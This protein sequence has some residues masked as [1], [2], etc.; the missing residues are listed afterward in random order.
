VQFP[1]ANDV[2]GIPLLQDVIDNF[3]HVFRTAKNVHNIDFLPHIQQRRVRFFSQRFLNVWVDGNDV[4]SLTLHVCG[5]AVARP[6]GAA[7][8]PDDRDG[9]GAL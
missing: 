2:L 5:D 3:F 6:Q 9:L 8:K 1:T 7:G 4:V